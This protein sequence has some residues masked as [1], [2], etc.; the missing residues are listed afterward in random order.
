[1]VVAIVLLLRLSFAPEL[2]LAAPEAPLPNEGW[3]CEMNH[4]RSA[5]DVIKVTV[6]SANA[7]LRPKGGIARERRARKRSARAIVP[8]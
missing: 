4:N 6:M 1:L 2:P 5:R 7:F 8:T 3:L